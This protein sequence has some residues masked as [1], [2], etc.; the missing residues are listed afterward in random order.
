[1][2]TYRPCFWIHLMKTCPQKTS[3][4]ALPQRW[5]QW[6]NSVL[7]KE[8]RQP[9]WYRTFDVFC[10]G[11]GTTPSR[12]TQGSTCS[13]H[14]VIPEATLVAPKKHPGIGNLTYRWWRKNNCITSWF[15]DS[16][17]WDLHHL[18]WKIHHLQ[19]YIML[20]C[21]V[22]QVDFHCYV[23]W[24][25]FIY[26][27]LSLGRCE[28]PGVFNFLKKGSWDLPRK[29]PEA[30]E[31]IMLEVMKGWGKVLQAIIDC[32]SMFKSFGCF[33]LDSNISSNSPARIELS[34]L[35]LHL[36]FTMILLVKAGEVVV[37]CPNSISPVGRWATN[38]SM[39]HRTQA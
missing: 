15:K 12:Q 10:P 30:H 5:Y 26:Y 7:N 36:M 20:W 16:H 18:H 38:F 37:V 27:P 31:K 39:A 33:N 21:Y 13:I 23:C 24:L 2:A 35:T 14:H 29:S 9:Y 22:E 32:R 1:M 19:F 3:Q 6:Y 17:I 34:Y 28:M 8:I 25:E 4:N 11:S